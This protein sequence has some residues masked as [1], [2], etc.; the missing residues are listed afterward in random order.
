MGPVT[1][2]DAHV[3]VRPGQPVELGNRVVKP[4]IDSNTDVSA[5]IIGPNI[6]LKFALRL[7]L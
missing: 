1:H 7:T 4:R 2:R 6:N 5:A 3:G